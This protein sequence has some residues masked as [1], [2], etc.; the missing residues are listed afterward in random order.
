MT[1]K[2]LI[3]RRCKKMLAG[4][5]ATATKNVLWLTFLLT[6]RFVKVL[7]CE[8]F[9]CMGDAEKPMKDTL[10]LPQ[11]IYNISEVPLL[12]KLGPLRKVQSYTH[13]RT[14]THRGCTQIINAN[15]KNKMTMWQINKRKQH[16]RVFSPML[17]PDLK[18]WLFCIQ[19]KQ[20]HFFITFSHFYSTTPLQWVKH[21]QLIKWKTI[22]TQF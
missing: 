17:R 1:R 5:A 22:L 21:L 18:F 6:V 3:A 7:V 14:H 11:N 2:Q 4:H 10:W 12:L 19:L 8:I 20:I 15:N 9:W 13:T 16:W